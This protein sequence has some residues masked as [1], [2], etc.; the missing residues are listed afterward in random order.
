MPQDREPS[1]AARDAEGVAIVA[2]PLL[3][4]GKTDYAAVLRLAAGV[5][6]AHPGEPGEGGVSSLVAD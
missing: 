3:G 2:P 5:S 4:W 1:P 6:D